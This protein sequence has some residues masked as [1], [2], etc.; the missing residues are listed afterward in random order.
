MT[1]KKKKQKLF[2]KFNFKE[3][4]KKNEINCFGRNSNFVSEALKTF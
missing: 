3:K 4:F 1:K 2:L